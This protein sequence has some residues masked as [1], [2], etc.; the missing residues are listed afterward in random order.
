MRDR[1][2]K[3]Q[4]HRQREE[5]TPRR[6]PDVGLNPGSP[7]SRPGQKAGAKLLSHPGITIILH[8]NRIHLL[9]LVH[10]LCY[11]LFLTSGTETSFDS[12][13]LAYL[14]LNW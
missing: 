10:K 12:C 3:R 14:G 6:E 13:K 5:Q 2:R 9:L 11:N 8:S 1:E 4:A 7:G